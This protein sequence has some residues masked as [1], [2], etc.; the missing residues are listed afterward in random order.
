MLRQMKVKHLATTNAGHP[1]DLLTQDEVAA[2]LKVSARAVRRLQ[3]DG[4]VPFI[5]L[6]K[7]VRYYWPAII[8]HLN[9]NCTVCRCV[10]V[11]APL[12]ARP[13]LKSKT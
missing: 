6:G 9:A 12:A 3:H 5:L 4:M 2:R 11:T 1:E 13:P 10:P 7:C 8:S